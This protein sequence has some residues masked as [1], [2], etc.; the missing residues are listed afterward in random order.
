VP[1]DKGRALCKDGEAVDAVDYERLKSR[2]RQERDAWPENLGLR[3]HRALS[4]LNRA[5]QLAEQD[6]LDGQF[7]FLWVAF[8]AAYATEIDEKYR[9][10]EQQTFR[11][12]LEK[13]AGLDAAQ[14]RF[15]A[16][17]W[18][19]FPK[20]I[21][22]L[23]D[24]RFVFAD[25]WNWQNGSLPE[26]E[27]KAKFAAANRAAHVALGRQDT[28]TVLSIVLSRIYVLRN[29]LVHGGATWGSSVN[30]EQLRDCTNFMA[31]LVPLV[32]EI[33]MDQPET[34]WGQGVYPVVK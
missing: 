24:N 27:Y 28:V 18:T 3:V 25:F 15:D 22:V 26:T 7:I 2:Q 23:L 30:R 1:A 10:S 20:S 17:V 5:E 31:K 29:Q 19:E 6:D 4:W 8:N 12:F 21:R 32:I 11:A 9:E 13:L 34:L 16:L 33:M 14:K